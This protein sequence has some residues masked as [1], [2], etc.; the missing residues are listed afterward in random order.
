MD[1]DGIHPPNQAACSNRLPDMINGM[2]Q[3]LKFMPREKLVQ[4]ITWNDLKFECLRPWPRE[5]SKDTCFV[6]N[7]DFSPQPTTGNQR[8]GLCTTQYQIIEAK[9]QGYK[10]IYD[11]NDACYHILLDEFTEFDAKTRRYKIYYNTVETN[12]LKL[13]SVA[14]NKNLAGIGFWWTL[15]ID[16]R[17]STCYKKFSYQYWQMMIKILNQMMGKNHENHENEDENQNFL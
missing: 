5:N 2:N 10:P 7:H 6:R 12:I 3:F 11:H 16:S 4:L 15:S 17:D 13:K 1:Y 9:T 14:V 8:L